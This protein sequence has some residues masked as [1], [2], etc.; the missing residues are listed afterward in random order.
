MLKKFTAV[1]WVQIISLAYLAVSVISQ[2]IAHSWWNAIYA[3]IALVLVVVIPLVARKLDLRLGDATMIAIILF[4][5]ISIYTGNKFGMYKRFWWY[6]VVLHFSSGTILALL[7]ADVMFPYGKLQIKNSWRDA[8]PLALVVVT[9]IAFSMA[10][11]AGWEIMEFI[12]DILLGN[13]VQRNLTVE[14][15]LLGASWQNPGIRD[16]MNDIV[17]GTAGALVG[18]P[19]IYFLRKRDR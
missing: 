6:D 13:D 15:E 9:A 14:Q 18:A 12:W 7:W 1:I 5:V 4:L 10:C 17:N 8:V 16:T 11:A 19:W 3:A 2:C